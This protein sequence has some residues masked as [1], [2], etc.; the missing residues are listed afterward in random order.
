MAAI[1]F[2]YELA[3]TYSYPAAMR[4]ESIAQAIGVEVRWRPFLLGAIF[5]KQG[6]STSPFNLFP[7]RGRHMWRDLERVCRA[8]ELPFRR[9]EPFP[10][11]S[12]TAARIALIGHD[13][14]WGIDFA[15]RVYNAEFGEGRD[16][17]DPETLRVI[18]ESLRLD[19]TALLAR[20]QGDEVKLRLRAATDEAMARGIFGAPSFVTPDGEVF[21]GNDRLEHALH[22]AKHG[23]LSGLVEPVR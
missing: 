7:V 3:S 23:S 10:Q 21:W 5:K 9:P 22:W 2:W 4:I 17:G 11:Q 8:M 20:A 16:I 14:G 6:W 18:I 19:A 13:E 12:L 15:Q 1:D